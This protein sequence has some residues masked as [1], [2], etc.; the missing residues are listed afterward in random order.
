MIGLLDILK[1]GELTEESLN[2][3]CQVNGKELTAVRTR[4]N[5]LLKSK[6]DKERLKDLL[7]KPKVKI[8]SLNQDVLNELKDI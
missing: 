6:G 8:D 5:Q 2:S 4:I 3:I 1:K 7:A